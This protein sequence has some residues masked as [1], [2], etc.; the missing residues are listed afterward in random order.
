MRAAYAIV[1]TSAAIIVV[2]GLAGF[3]MGS[4]WQVAV[5]GPVDAPPRE[6]V[7]Y[8]ADF[9]T[10]RQWSMWN[11]RNFPESEFSYRGASAGSAGAQQV[12]KMGPK[13][14]VWHL[15][16]VK[17]NELIYWRQTNEGPVRNG[18]FQVEST[19]DGTH[20]TWTVW[21]DAGFNPYARLIAWFLSDRVR[22]QLR[23]GLQG[24]QQHFST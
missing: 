6:V 5:S 22:S 16:T 14:T 3:A 13:T 4:R 15:Q 7:A 19:P 17:S 9:R 23:A 24:I 18:R 1:L 21:G 10:W 12:W 8:L 2:A 20:L 11:T